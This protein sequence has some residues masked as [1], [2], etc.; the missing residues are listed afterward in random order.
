MTPLSAS[1]YN[2]FLFVQATPTT[3]ASDDVDA[4]ALTIV[5]MTVVFTALVM[6]GSLIALIG[7]LFQQK[8]QD[9]EPDTKSVETLTPV[10]SGDGQVDGH[11]LALLT[12]AAYAAVGRPVEIRRITFINQNTVSAWRE[13]GRISIHGS[14][15]L[16]R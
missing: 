1:L 14:H 3:A 13:M 16:K 10:G 8:V 9:V 7:R 15:N 5:G 4:L 6:T 11:T 2:L 12:A